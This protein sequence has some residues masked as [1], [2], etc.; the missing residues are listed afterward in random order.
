[1]RR[2][3]VVVKISTHKTVAL[4]LTKSTQSALQQ[5]VG[6]VGDADSCLALPSPV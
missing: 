6:V 4:E 2:L 5:G 3:C 1:M